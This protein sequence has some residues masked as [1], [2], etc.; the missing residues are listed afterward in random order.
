MAGN[1]SWRRAPLI[2][3]SEDATGLQRVRAAASAPRVQQQEFEKMKT[4][5][6]DAAELRATIKN[7][8]DGK[9]RSGGFMPPSGNQCNRE[10]A[11]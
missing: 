10:M 3:H 2:E 11:G 9:G 7:L 6:F 4:S 8:A 1:S 5:R